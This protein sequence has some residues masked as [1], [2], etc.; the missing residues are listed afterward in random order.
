VSDELRSFFVYLRFRLPLKGKTLDAEKL[1]A[2]FPA[3][4]RMQLPRIKLSLIRKDTGMN[5]KTAAAA[6]TSLL[7]KL[8]KNVDGTYK[9][10][11][12]IILEEYSVL[13]CTSSYIVANPAFTDD[14]LWRDFCFVLEKNGLLLASERKSLAPVKEILTLH[15]LSSM[16]LTE[17][18]LATGWSAG[19]RAGISENAV[20]VGA[21]A[22]SVNPEGPSHI[23]VAVFT[24]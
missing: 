2:D 12:E 21:F 20:G 16:H 19:L 1:P 22:P 13:R 5:R 4:M 6:L 7:A 8:A 9:I 23:G 3:A 10:F 14:I 15:A 17:I 24:T 18:L 11:Q